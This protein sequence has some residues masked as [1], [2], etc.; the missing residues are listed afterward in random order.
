MLARKPA[1]NSASSPPS[2]TMPKITCYKLK[3][4]FTSLED[5]D[6]GGMKGHFI[7]VVLWENNEGF[8]VHVN[9]QS[10]QSF[11]MTWEQFSALKKIIKE[12]DK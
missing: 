5:W 2:W 1:A 9:S 3:A 11:N 8:D 7:E 4:A 6:V 12:L 10:H